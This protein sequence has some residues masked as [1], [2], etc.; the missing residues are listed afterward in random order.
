MYLCSTKCCRYIS[1]LILHI[2]VISLI[3]VFVGIINIFM[4]PFFLWC[5][6]HMGL[7]CRLKVHCVISSL[8]LENKN[9]TVIIITFTSLMYPLREV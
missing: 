3:I 4:N 2:L 1:H 5:I 8:K 9:I 6:N 7:L